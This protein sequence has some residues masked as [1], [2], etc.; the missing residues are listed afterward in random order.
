MSNINILL[1][2]L[3]DFKQKGKGKYVALC[4]VH[5]EKTPSLHIKELS[6]DR[7]IMHCFGCGANG[8]E[9]CQSLNIDLDVLFPE[10]MPLE[11]YRRERRP[12]NAS[13]IL[14]SLLHEAT[15]LSIAASQIV[16]GKPLNKSDSERIELARKRI[17]GAVHYVNS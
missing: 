1:N 6:D 9:I 7:I 17:D 2:A 13:E 12:F 15:V 4:P 16:H 10:K 14:S 3:T 8:V 11:G 5:N